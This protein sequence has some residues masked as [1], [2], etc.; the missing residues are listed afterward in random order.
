VGTELAIDGPD[1][2]ELNGMLKVLCAAAG[3]SVADTAIGYMSASF[4]SALTVVDTQTYE[5]V[6]FPLFGLSDS[7]CGKRPAQRRFEIDRR[8]QLL[9]YH[10]SY[11]RKTWSCYSKSTHTRSSYCRHRI[12]LPCRERSQRLSPQ[13]SS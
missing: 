13:H 7:T 11:Y 2:A 12:H 6:R 1:I 8:M 4:V 9:H 5:S 3:V 10:R